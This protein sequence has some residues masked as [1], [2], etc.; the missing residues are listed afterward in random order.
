MTAPDRWV[1]MR[2][3]FGLS[4]VP[5]DDAL[6]I[7]RALAVALGANDVSPKARW[8]I[9]TKWAADY[10]T[11]EQ[12]RARAAVAGYQQE[13]PYVERADDVIV[14]LCD[15]QREKVAAGQYQAELNTAGLAGTVRV[16]FC[17]GTRTCGCDCHNQGG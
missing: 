8:Q 7:R 15:C 10:L 12:A 5:P 2:D 3:L 9:V 6:V 17:N 14:Y 11:D 16:W 4:V 13:V 1:R